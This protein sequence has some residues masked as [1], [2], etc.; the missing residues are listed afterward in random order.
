MAKERCTF[1]AFGALPT[2]LENP[3]E[4]IVF[5]PGRT[6]GAMTNN[7]LAVLVG[8]PWAK[9]SS[10]FFLTVCHPEIGL[11]GARVQWLEE[12]CTFAAFGALPTTL[13]NPLEEIVFTPGRTH[14]RSRSPR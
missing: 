13:E 6:H 1:A 8:R 10:L 2:S 11:S 9:K 12:R 14:N 4:E 3:L 7:G 5:T